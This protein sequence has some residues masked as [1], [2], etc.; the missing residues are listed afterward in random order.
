MPSVFIYCWLNQQIWE[1]IANKFWL[2]AYGKE[3]WVQPGTLMAMAVITQCIKYARWSLLT[4]TLSWE[5]AQ[6]VMVEKSGKCSLF[7]IQPSRI[8]IAKFWLA[9][10]ILIS[11]SSIIHLFIHNFYL[12]HSWNNE[13]CVKCV[14][15]VLYITYLLWIHLFQA[16]EVLIHPFK[17]LFTIFTLKMALEQHGFVLCG[18]TYVQ[19]FSLKYVLQ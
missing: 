8:L 4:A 16:S 2:I 13:F 12:Y 11:S 5:E 10:N 7:V 3:N 19:I 18:S 9:P 6:K 15:A 14:S 17:T 1:V